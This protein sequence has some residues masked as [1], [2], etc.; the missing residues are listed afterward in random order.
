MRPLRIIMSYWWEWIIVMPWPAL[1]QSYVSVLAWSPG[2]GIRFQCVVWTPDVYSVRRNGWREGMS[3]HRP[4]ALS[5]RC[6]KVWHDSLCFLLGT[7]RLFL[8][9][10]RR[11]QLSLSLSFCPSVSIPSSSESGLLLQQI[12]TLKQKQLN[13]HPIQMSNP[14]RQ[15]HLPKLLIATLWICCS[16]RLPQSGTLRSVF[17]YFK[18]SNG[19]AGFLILCD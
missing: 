17:F 1:I 5:P 18:C 15:A 8:C 11:C 13:L 3:A 7:A 12:R 19:M 16:E 4:L 9:L 14:W 6:E 10:S 2:L